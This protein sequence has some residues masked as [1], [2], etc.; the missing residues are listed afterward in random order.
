MGKS[1]TPTYR[2]ET[3]VNPGSWIPFSTWDYKEQGKPTEK[4]LEAYRIKLN[5]SY[6]PNG[7]NYHIS[8]AYGFIVHYSKA[9][10]VNQ[11]TRQI[12]CETNA[13]MF[14]AV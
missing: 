11:F 3:S 7:V 4:K 6:Q 9:R 13:P 2:I 1:F 10:V 5:E 8:K 14:E 12:V